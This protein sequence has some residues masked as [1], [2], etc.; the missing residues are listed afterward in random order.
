MYRCGVSQQGNTI[1]TL[2]LWCGNTTQESVRPKPQVCS[3]KVEAHGRYQLCSHGKESEYPFKLYFLVAS[4]A[5]TA[6]ACGKAFLLLRL[7]FQ[8][9]TF[10][11]W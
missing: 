6:A 3:M 2:E 10:S 5:G 8:L 11:N 7:S 1:L 9:G 4:I